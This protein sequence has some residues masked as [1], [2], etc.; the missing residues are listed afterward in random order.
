MKNAVSCSFCSFIWLV[1]LTRRQRSDLCDLRIKLPPI[2]MSLTTQKGR[3][4]LVKENYEKFRF[5]LKRYPCINKNFL[6][7]SVLF[8]SSWLPKNLKKC[9]KWND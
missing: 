1:A 8:N 7:A 4:N 9:P 6:V 3:G 2:I 5:T